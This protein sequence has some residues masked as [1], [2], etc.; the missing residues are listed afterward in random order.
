MD[1]GKDKKTD[2]K[3]VGGHAM[4]VAP[5]GAAAII[6]FP[7]L[8]EKWG[9]ILESNKGKSPSQKV[10]FFGRIGRL[11]SALLW[12]GGVCVGAVALTNLMKDWREK[13]QEE[14][15]KKLPKT[16]PAKKPISSPAS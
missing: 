12:T 1:G 13:K 7:M 3:A 8:A 4:Q 11:F 5:M 16:M 15:K 14:Q 2:W 10:G 6:G 9:S